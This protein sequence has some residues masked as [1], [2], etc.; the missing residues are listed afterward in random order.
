[1]YRIAADI[2]VVLHLLFIVFVVLGGVLV[3]RWPRVAWAHLPCA[4]YG[5]LIE[6]VGWICP[7][8]PLEHR[9]RDMAGHGGYEGGFVEHYLLPI[10]YPSG[11]TA[12]VQLVLGAAVLVI[13][14]ALYAAVIYRHKK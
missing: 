4:V 9:L 5:V 2:V 13:N 7:L 6:W 1:M 8:T 12:N 11:L 14:V 3:L 10:I